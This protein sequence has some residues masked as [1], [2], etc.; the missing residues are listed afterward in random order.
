MSICGGFAVGSDLSHL[1]VPSPICW[2]KL[3][4][5]RGAALVHRLSDQLGTTRVGTQDAV[6]S[7]LEHSRPPPHALYCRGQQTARLPL[8]RWRLDWAPC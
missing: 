7:A 8:G 6:P 1:P 3:L 2:M 4:K 5:S